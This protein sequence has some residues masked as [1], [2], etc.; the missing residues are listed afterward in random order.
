MTTSP[1]SCPREI[2]A[3]Q[4]LVQVFI[5]DTAR[6]HFKIVAAATEQFKAGIS[7][8]GCLSLKLAGHGAAPVATSSCR[9]CDAS[10]T[11]CSCTA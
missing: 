5:E 8:R 3:I 9:G 6:L 10:R 4:R 7:V 2:V 1:R 11:M